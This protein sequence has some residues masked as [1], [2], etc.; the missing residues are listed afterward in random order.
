MIINTGMM[1]T[2]GIVIDYC[3]KIGLFG[4]AFM[5]IK[6]LCNF[7]PHIFSFGEIAIHASSFFTYP[8][9]LQERETK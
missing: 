4:M 2:L 9:K 3:I 7:L 1:G 8:C 6:I 5:G